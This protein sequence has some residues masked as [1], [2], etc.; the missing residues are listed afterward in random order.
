MQRNF[1]IASAQVNKNGEKPVKVERKKEKNVEKMLTYQQYR[2]Q[3]QNTLSAFRAEYDRKTTKEKQRIDDLNKGSFSPIE[4]QKKAF[5]N[6]TKYNMA[7]ES[8]RYMNLMS[9][10]V[11]KPKICVFFSCTLFFGL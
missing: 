11:S 3:F 2:E 8:A 9:I 4:Q 6:I 10:N 7:R 5:E 1:C